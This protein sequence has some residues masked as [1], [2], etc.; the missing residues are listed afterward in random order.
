MVIVVGGAF[1]RGNTLPSLLFGFCWATIVYCPL[2]RWTLSSSGWL[3]NL[4]SLDYA[5]G[6][7]VHIASGCTALAYAL[8]LGKHK[9]DGPKTSRSKPH[10]ATLVFLGSVMIWFGWLGFNVCSLFGFE[11]GMY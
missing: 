4:P 7:P 3:Y 6:G 11:L 1:E 9:S 2:A 8:V 10:N 5:S